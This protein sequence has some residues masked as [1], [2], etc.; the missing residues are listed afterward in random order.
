MSRLFVQR[1]KAPNGK[2]AKVFLTEILCGA[3][4]RVLAVGTK[5][6]IGNRSLPFLNFRGELRRKH[7]RELIRLDGFLRTATHQ[8]LHYIR[9][10][11]KKMRGHP[12]YEFRIGRAI[13]LFWVFG[14]ER[15]IICLTG[16][17][18]Q[19]AR[20]PRRELRRAEAW[21]RAYD[22]RA[23]PS[24]EARYNELELFIPQIL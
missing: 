10:H 3:C 24:Q 8:G 1:P 13:R 11:A 9:S 20:T 17:R 6:G 16:Y 2:G 18:K 5:N 15:S 14:L 21:R 7:P 4:F 12:F 22:Q 19:S 23:L